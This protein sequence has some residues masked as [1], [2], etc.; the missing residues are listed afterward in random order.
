M[1]EHEGVR[2][3]TTGNF[4]TIGK[5]ATPSI[6]KSNY[7]SVLYYSIQVD[8]TVLL[9]LHYEHISSKYSYVE[10]LHKTHVEVRFIAVF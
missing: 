7:Q 3:E 2:Q 1:C 4:S 8:I 9:H 10:K 5:L 6:L